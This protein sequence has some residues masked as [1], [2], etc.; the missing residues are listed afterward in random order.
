MNIAS[1]SA[2]CPF[3]VCAEKKKSSVCTQPWLCNSTIPANQQQGAF[4][5]VYRTRERQWEQAGWQIW[6]T[7]TCWTP[8]HK[9]TVKKERWQRN[10]CYDQ[11]RE[12]SCINIGEAFLRWRDLRELKG[13]KR[14][15]EVSVS[16]WQAGNISFSLFHRAYRSVESIAVWSWC[17]LLLLATL[18]L[19]RPR[20]RGTEL[21]HDS[22]ETEITS[23]ILPCQLVQKIF[24]LHL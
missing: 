2:S 14:D 12:K 5:L 20:A 23:E 24:W 22:N 17:P 11:A 10:T 9:R 6:H 7:L 16:A 8:Q 13:M 1:R 18:A 3:C 15:V 4:M 21:R 19:P